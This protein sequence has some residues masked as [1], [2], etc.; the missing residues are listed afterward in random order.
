MIA[1]SARIHHLILATRNER[2]FVQW[3]LRVVNPFK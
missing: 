3:G 1:A 2:D